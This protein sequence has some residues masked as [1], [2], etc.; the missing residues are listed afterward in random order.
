MR[1]LAA[2]LL[3]GWCA[4]CYDFAEP[5]FP[6]AGAPAYLQV[7]AFVDNAG[8]ASINALLTP[9][10]AIGGVLRPVPNDT[11]KVF[12]L[13]LA[14]TNVRK[15]GTREYSFNGKLVA[16]DIY[17]FRLNG[18]RVEEI[19][20]PAPTADWF[21]IRKTDPDTVIW[22]RGTDLVLH[23]QTDLGTSLPKPDIRQWFLD[24]SGSDR[25]FRISSDGFPPATLRIPSEWLPQ[26]SSGTIV[27]ALSFYQAGR[28]QSPASDYIGNLSYTLQL[29][30]LV[31]VKE[32]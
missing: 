6:E 15:N 2:V 10:L 5:D 29:R 27:A 13:S 26:A 4:A 12:S 23:V 17:E 18:P 25:Q 3:A 7:D 14:P 16:Q 21:G 11:L 30:W 31:R 19:Q 20:G 28:Q 1:T 8:N 24:L 32:P 9:G 22:T